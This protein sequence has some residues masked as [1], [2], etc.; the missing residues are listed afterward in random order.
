M[1]DAVDLINEFDYNVHKSVF[2]SK[3]NFS[4][5]IETL[6]RDNPGM[7]YFEAILRFSNESDKEP[8]ELLPFMEDVL[9]EKVRKSAVD[10]E[11]H[12]EETYSLDD[13]VK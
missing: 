1:K 6:V 5:Y 4:N 9:L 7:T 2:L 11:L 12:K 3:S 10:L 13:L 8:E